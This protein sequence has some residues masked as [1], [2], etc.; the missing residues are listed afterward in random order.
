MNPEEAG[1]FRLDGFSK[2]RLC[3]PGAGFGVGSQGE[4]RRKPRLFFLPAVSGRTSVER[5]FESDEMF[6]GRD[7]IVTDKGTIRPMVYSARL[8]GGAVLS[9]IVFR[10][11]ARDAH[12]YRK[13]SASVSEQNPTQTGIDNRC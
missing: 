9:T 12:L 11:M 2:G 7:T 3:G 5:A 8:P 6:V 1:G 4:E 13:F 10:T